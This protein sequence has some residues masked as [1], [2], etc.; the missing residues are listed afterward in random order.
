MEI[1]QTRNKKIKN[2]K[3]LLFFLTITTINYVMNKTPK[4]QP[5]KLAKEIYLDSLE[6]SYVS[7][8]KALRVY[9]PIALKCNAKH[10]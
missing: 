4:P 1:H 6:R 9:M 3:L 7:K 10:K 5:S 8:T 2:M